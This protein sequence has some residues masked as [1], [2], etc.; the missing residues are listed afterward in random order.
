MGR[1]CEKS[2]SSYRI[3]QETG[4]SQAHPDTGG[5]AGRTGTC[6]DEVFPS[7]GDYISAEKI[8]SNR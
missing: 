2:V 8:P 4:R 6:Q 3:A 7:W 1:R 5:N